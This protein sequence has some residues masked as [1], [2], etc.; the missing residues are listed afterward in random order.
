[1]FLFVARVR[2]SVW[3]TCIDGADTRTELDEKNFQGI[4]M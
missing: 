1:V 2:P 3:G 4:L